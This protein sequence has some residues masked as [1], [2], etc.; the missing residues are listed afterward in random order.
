MR[1]SF[2]IFFGDSFT[3]GMGL[4]YKKTFVGLIENSQKDYKILNF[5]VPGYSP[6]VFS[7][8]L[9]KTIKGLKEFDIRKKHILKK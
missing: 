3:Y 8:Q 5:G 1:I 2:L 9:K 7:Y 4:D 6:S